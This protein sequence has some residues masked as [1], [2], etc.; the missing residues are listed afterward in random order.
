MSLHRCP[1]CRCEPAPLNLSAMFAN[2]ECRI[3]AQPRTPAGEWPHTQQHLSR[4]EAV[5]DT[6]RVLPVTDVKWGAEGDPDAVLKPQTVTRKL[7]PK[8]RAIVRKASR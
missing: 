7:D 4:G 2:G 1:S 8:L 3:C 6:G 5:T